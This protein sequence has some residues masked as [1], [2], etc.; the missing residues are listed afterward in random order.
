M[1]NTQAATKTTKRKTASKALKIIV[2]IVLMIAIA[3]AAAL[4]IHKTDRSVPPLRRRVV[5]RPMIWLCKTAIPAIW[6]S[7]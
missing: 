2:A 4:I 5:S 3:F 6:N 7:G 1:E